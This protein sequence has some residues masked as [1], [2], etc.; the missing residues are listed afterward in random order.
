MIT[1][2]SPREIELMRRSGKITATAHAR[3]VNAQSSRLNAS[4]YQISTTAIGCS[5]HSSNSSTFLATGAP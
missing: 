5:R 4:W 1:L 3:R 2:K